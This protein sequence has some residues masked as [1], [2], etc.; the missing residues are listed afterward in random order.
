MPVPDD[1][2]VM[3]TQLNELVAV[4]EHPA[5][6]VTAMVAEPPAAGRDSLPG[7]IE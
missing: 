6:A 1:P 2:P 3:V 4:H 7:L 5:P